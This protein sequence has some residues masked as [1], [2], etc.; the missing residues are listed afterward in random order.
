M[1][2]LEIT[3]CCK[4]CRHIKIDMKET[5]Y[6]TGHYHRNFYSLSCI[7]EPVCARLEKELSDGKADENV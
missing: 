7:H 5:D 6:F 1:V 3:G 4:D 2:K